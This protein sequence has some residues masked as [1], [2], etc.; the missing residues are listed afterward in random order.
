MVSSH[1][2]GVDP[3]DLSHLHADKSATK[4][5]CIHDLFYLAICTSHP[6]EIKIA[7]VYSLYILSLKLTVHT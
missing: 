3:S 1:F 4:Q 7:I 6:E 2:G 5:V